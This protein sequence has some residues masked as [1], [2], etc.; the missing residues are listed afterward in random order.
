MRTKITLA[1]LFLNAA[2]FA[3]IF[4]FERDTTGAAT[5]NTFRTTNSRQP[6]S[7]GIYNQNV[8]VWNTALYFGF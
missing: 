8:F 1:L 7:E 5:A 4:Y 6:S 2:L 3:F